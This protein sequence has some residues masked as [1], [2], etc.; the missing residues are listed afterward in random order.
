MKKM[1]NKEPGL[2]SQL[3]ELAKSDTFGRYVLTNVDTSLAA[4]DEDIIRL[5]A[6][7]VKDELVREEIMTLLLEELSLTREMMMDLLESPISE[8]RVNHHHSTRLRAEALQPLHREQVSLL[9]KWRKARKEGDA[10]KDEQLLQSLL[11]SINAIA[12]AMGTTG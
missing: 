7:L 9:K 10:K 5:Y 6:G 4:T 11:Q 3:K 1:Q 2:W 8:R 12:N